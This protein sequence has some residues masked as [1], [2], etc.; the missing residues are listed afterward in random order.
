MIYLIQS[1]SLDEAYLDLTEYLV[2]HPKLTV[3]N[4]SAEIR[5]RICVATGGLTASGGIACNRM[6]AKVFICRALP[7]LG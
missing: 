2:A 5:Q 6:L 1:M 7:L 4:V 3:D